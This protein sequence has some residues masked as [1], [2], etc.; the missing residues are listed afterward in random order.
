MKRFLKRLL[1]VTFI[2]LFANC[3]QQV[4][5][6]RTPEPEP[7]VDSNAQLEDFNPQVLNDYD[8]KMESA[9]SFRQDV[10]DL[11]L[12]LKGNAPSETP[13]KRETVSG[14]RVQL[15]ST[16]N[17]Q[18]ARNVLREGLLN[19]QEKVYLVFDNP[20]YKVRV[21]DCLS[22]YEANDLQETA[23]QKGFWEAWVVRTTVNSI[24]V[25]E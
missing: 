9:G 1:L 14:Y 10:A 5:L 22:R 6:K 21:G 11:D 18:E 20:Y 12:I 24:N 15:I 3:A 16:R 7:A 2:A 4:P 19:F 13:K 25:T 23:R 8:L 17:E